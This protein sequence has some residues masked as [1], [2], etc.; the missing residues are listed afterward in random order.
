MS[1]ARSILPV[2]YAP[3]RPELV[4]TG[5]MG[6]VYVVHFAR[7]LAHARHYTGWTTN[8]Q[9]RM[10][11]HRA[12][13]GGRLMATVQAAGI[14]WFITHTE[15]GDRNRERQIKNRSNGARRLCW[16]CRVEEQVAAQGSVAFIQGPTRAHVAR[17]EGQ[18]AYSSICAYRL[19]RPWQFVRHTADGPPSVPWCGWCT[20]KVRAV[21]TA[22]LGD[23]EL[24]G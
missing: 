3:T 2:R 18:G 5:Q 11:Q 20:S 1:A 9:Q 4:N 16:A 22:V 24:V 8:L 19:R 17:F 7:P 12:G 15:V 23:L 21:A 10:S 14:P 13:F 6:V